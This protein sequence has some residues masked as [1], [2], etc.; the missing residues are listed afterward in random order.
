MTKEHS[1]GDSAPVSVSSLTTSSGWSDS[2]DSEA[3]TFGPGQNASQGS[4]VLPSG[5]PEWRRS[6]NVATWQDE[7]PQELNMFCRPRREHSALSRQGASLSGPDVHLSGPDVH[8]SGPDVHLSGPDVHLSGPDVHLSGPDVHL[9]GQNAAVSRCGAASLGC[10]ADLS[11]QN[12]DL[13][14]QAA[15]IPWQETPVDASVQQVPAAGT[16]NHGYNVESFSPVAVTVTTDWDLPARTSFRHQKGCRATSSGS[17]HVRSRLPKPGQNTAA[18]TAAQ[19]VSAAG[20]SGC[21]YRVN[22]FGSNPATAFTQREAAVTADGRHKDGT[23]HRTNRLRKASQHTLQETSAEAGSMGHR[24]NRLRKAAQDTLEEIS[25]QQVTGTSTSDCI[26]EADPFSSAPRTTSTEPEPVVTTEC[27]RKR[28]DEQTVH[29]SQQKHQL[30]SVPVDRPVPHASHPLHRRAISRTDLDATYTVEEIGSDGSSAAR[31]PWASNA[32]RCLSR[33][34]PLQ[35]NSPGSGESPSMQQVSP[36]SGESPSLQQVSPGSRESPSQQKVSPVG[37]QSLPQQLVSP[38]GGQSPVHQQV[39]PRDGESPPPQQVSPVGAQSPPSA[40]ATQTVT[41]V[42]Q[43]DRRCSSLRDVQRAEL[44]ADVNRASCEQPTCASVCSEPKSQTCIAS[45]SSAAHS[46][47]SA[48]SPNS[49]STNCGVAGHRR[50][51]QVDAFH[52]QRTPPH[53]VMF[54]S[55]SSSGDSDSSVLQSLLS[56]LVRK[57]FAGEGR[58]IDSGEGGKTPAREGRTI[59]SGEG[60]KTPAREGRTIASGE[61][62][63]TPARE[64]RMMDS[65]EGRDTPAREGMMMDS[66]KGGKTPAREGR[67]M[68]SKKGGKTPARE[69]RMIDS[70]EGRDTPAREGRMMDSKKGGKTPAREGRMIDSGEGRD[71]PAREGRM[72]DSGEGRETPTGEGRTLAAREGRPA[73]SG[74]DRKTCSGESREIFARE[75]RQ[76]LSGVVRKTF[77]GENGKTQ[78]GESREI[79][80]RENRQ[81]LSGEGRKTLPGEGRKTPVWEGRRE[82]SAGESR[83]IPTEESRNLSAKEG[84]ETPALEGKVTPSGEV[85]KASTGEGRKTYA[86]EGRETIAKDSGKT[87]SGEGRK[88]YAREKRKTPAWQCRK[89]CIGGNKETPAVKGRKMCAEANGKTPAGEDRKI[90]AGK[91]RET[92]AQKGREMPSGKDRKTP[93]EEPPG[94]LPT[95]GT[96]SR[97]RCQPGGVDSSS[98]SILSVTGQRDGSVHSVTDPR[99]NSGHTVTDPR[100]NSGHTVTDQG[101]N[102]GHKVTDRRDNSSHTVTDQRDNCGHTVTDQRDNSGHTV[103]DHR[104]NSGHTVTDHRDNSGHTVTDHRDNSGHTDQ[105]GDSVDTITN[106]TR[107]HNPVSMAAG[108]RDDSVH[109]VT[110]D[111]VRRSF[112]SDSVPLSSSSHG[113]ASADITGL[114]NRLDKASNNRGHQAASESCRYRCMMPSSKTKHGLAKC[115]GDAPGDSVQ[116]GTEMREPLPEKPAPTAAKI[117]PSCSKNYT[118]PLPAQQRAGRVAQ[119]NRSGIKNCSILK[120]P[121]GRRPAAETVSLT[122][123]ERE[124]KAFSPRRAKSRAKAGICT[125]G[126]YTVVEHLQYRFT[127]SPAHHD[128]FRPAAALDTE[129]SALAEQHAKSTSGKKTPQVSLSG[130]TF[131]SEAGPS[132]GQKKPRGQPKSSLVKAAK[133]AEGNPGCTGPQSQEKPGKISLTEPWEPAQAREL[134]HRKRTRAKRQLAFAEELA[135]KQR[136]HTGRHRS[137]VGTAVERGPRSCAVSSVPP[138]SDQPASTPLP[139]PLMQKKRRKRR[140]SAQHAERRNQDSKR[141]RLESRGVSLKTSD[142]QAQR[143]EPKRVL[144]KTSNMQASTSAV[145]QCPSSPS[146]ETETTMSSLQA[147]GNGCQSD[148]HTRGNVSQ[149]HPGTP[150]Q[151]S[152]KAPATLT[153]AT[154]EGPWQ[155]AVDSTDP[156]DEDRNTVDLPSDEPDGSRDQVVMVELANPGMTNNSRFTGHFSPGDLLAEVSG[157]LMVIMRA[158]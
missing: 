16:S 61:G 77:L 123:S 138:P 145:A 76:A 47:T 48:G 15:N 157:I 105:S 63:K 125:L 137:T 18:E 142:M 71:T 25:A 119:R 139:S 100:D 107:R 80:A 90:C 96:G 4:R 64:G 147:G 59:A 40:V 66:K 158:A 50:T 27:W 43:R 53:D 78:S 85:R 144:L 73:L 111:S 132:V 54:D 20:A 150:G 113:V 129:V 126:G 1:A 51:A 131:D 87:L 34:A 92:P 8:L 148:L 72:M 94:R 67:M 112:H 124:E 140:G 41:S 115:T 103:T 104:D 14:G 133:S 91:D 44:A 21:G 156:G 23:A 98:W 62:G 74:E 30:A 65:G 58:M 19:R 39:S 69:G 32:D 45:F 83:E 37:G 141:R 99:D 70:G 68:D 3:L 24:M 11:G 82:S 102:S 120:T 42:Q 17:D 52:W 49:T 6:S 75:G 118:V 22:A 153:C 154:A 86:K 127:K 106:Q 149:T 9:S 114:H 31:R 130:E 55:D 88:T 5:N 135:G 122:S 121:Q 13:L 108:Q 33:F 26:Y 152:S 2:E 28:P 36:S 136:G 84:R 117:E 146:D 134:P 109:T 38:V 56:A 46:G 101:D 7:S 143:L 116:S 81:T 79:F 57:A 93:A 89:I 10:D 151:V 95:G 128:A 110:D 97:S 155:V 35:Q 29:S 12:A 60:R